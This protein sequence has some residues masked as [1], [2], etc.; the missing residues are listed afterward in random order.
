LRFVN[1]SVVPATA[2]TFVVETGRDRRSIVDD[3][4]FN[5]GVPIEHTFA[6]F[7][8][9]REVSKATWTVSQVDFADG[10]AWHM[11]NAEADEVVRRRAELE[12]LNADAR[13]IAFRHLGTSL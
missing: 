2:V 6:G 7:D 11:A 13:R 12:Q 10:T 5:P 4:T 8:A 9:L 3:G 1:E